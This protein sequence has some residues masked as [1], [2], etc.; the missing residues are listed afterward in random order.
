MGKDLKQS[1]NPEKRSRDMSRKE[2]LDLLVTSP[3][4]RFGEGGRGYWLTPP[5]FCG[6]LAS[7]SLH[8]DRAS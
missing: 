3:K 4:S 5:S 6:K 7:L 1:R 2:N 8:L